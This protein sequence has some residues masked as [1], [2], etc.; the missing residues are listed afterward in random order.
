MPIN[1]HRGLVL[2]ICIAAALLLSACVR[3]AELAAPVQPVATDAEGET[4]GPGRRE[5]SKEYWARINATKQAAARTRALRDRLGMKNSAAAQ[6]SPQTGPNP[7]TWTFLGPQPIATS[8]PSNPLSG[9]IRD[10]ILDPHNSAVMYVL[11]YLGKIWK[12]SNSGQSWAPL[13]DFG[14]LTVVDTLVAD[15]IQPNTLYA[16]NGDLFAS[17]DGGETWNALAPVVED[18]A[19]DCQSIAFAVSPSGGAWLALEG[20]PSEPSL[21]GLYRST[22]GGTTWSAVLGPNY[23]GTV[24]STAPLFTLSAGYGSYGICDLRFNSGSGSYAYVAVGPSVFLSTDQGATWTN[25]SPPSQATQPLEI[26]LVPAAS[27]PTTLYLLWGTNPSGGVGEFTNVL[28]KSTNGGASWQQA[29]NLP[30]DPGSPRS[31]SLLSVHPL[32][33]TLVFFGSVNLFRSQDGGN[34]WQNVMTGSSG[35][36]L[37]ADQHALVFAQDNATLYET[38]DGGIWKATQPYA[39]KID[40]ASLNSG[41]GTA[42]IYSPISI[43]PQN[44]NRAFAGTQD[45]TTLQYAGSPGW[46]QAGV[47]GDGFGTA[48]N[49]ASPTTVY[50]ACNGGLFGSTQ[51]GAPG[52]WVQL[53]S[54]L[55]FGLL[56]FPRVAVDPSTPSIV[57]MTGPM[58]TDLYQ[59]LDGGNSWRVMGSSFGDITQIQVSPSSSNV[60]YVVSEPGVQL[61]VTQNALSTALPTWQSYTVP[62]ADGPLGLAVD[63]TNPGTVAVFTEAE[64]GVG[65][66]SYYLFSISMDGGTT[67]RST[68]VGQGRSDYALTVATGDF[69]AN[70]YLA[71]DPDI[72]G[73]WYITK[74]LSVYRSSDDG[75]T[76]YPLATGLPLVP[77]SGVALQRASRTLWAATFGRGVWN[78]SIPVTAP[79]LSTA[80]LQPNAAATSGALTVTGQNFDANSVVQVNGQALTTTF[81]SASE[82][83]ASVSTGT[84]PTGGFYYISVYKPGSAGGVSD[85]QQLAVGTF[86]FEGGLVS[87]ADALDTQL[88]PGAIMSIYGSGLASVTMS[89]G[90]VPLPLTLG[91][92]QVFVNSVPSPLLYVSPGQINFV[93]PWEVTGQT[94][95]AVVV[96]DGAA[97][98][99]PVQANVGSAAPA[100]FTLNQQG[101]GAVLIAGTGI[102]AAPIGAFPNSRPVQVGEYIEIYATGLGQ[103]A[104]TPT[105]GQGAGGLDNILATDFYVLWNCGHYFCSFGQ[106]TYVGL[107]PDFPG[108]YQI[109][110]QVPVTG[111]TGAVALSLA[112]GEA[113]N[114]GCLGPQQSN[115]FTIAVQ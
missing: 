71:T 63:A 50:A 4:E 27:A 106:P 89:A 7:F 82:L 88:I 99:P 48:I 95:A 93:V 51:G 104:Q 85:P 30:P 60:V 29:T 38:G 94:Q 74:D 76:W 57:Y 54:S 65:I 16:E 18:S 62:L 69:Y 39:A 77:G 3:R 9:S 19:E 34:T 109:D 83:A 112:I 86:V 40:W 42:E 87:S 14:P 103:V 5:T 102:I 1:A 107:A 21:G 98:S 56:G 92:V 20:C 78:L 13:L 81:V 24:L 114:Q 26:H 75:Q 59:S 110:I 46:T 84:F 10:I 58:T 113:C 2:I 36:T 72:P 41:L 44:P 49:P 8:N 55:N 6:T 52:T 23:L 37:H 79:R 66:S 80:S 12:T 25:A 53:N 108:L 45:N 96:H 47:C 67:W 61:W 90:A 70:S 43:D 73:T 28:F 91:G 15:P 101:Q 111:V 68:P 35:I 11:T 105:D 32:D 17:T 33:P 22:D 64:G 115:A 100:V 31:P 97:Q